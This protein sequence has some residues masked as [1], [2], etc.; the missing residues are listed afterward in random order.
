MFMYTKN[1]WGQV[2]KN[3]LLEETGTDSIQ[4]R[5][6]QLKVNEDPAL[7]LLRTAV[8][9][10]ERRRHRWRAAQRCA[11]QA[12]AKEE[13]YTHVISH[14]QEMGEAVFHA[15]VIQGHEERIDDDTQ[16][17]EQLHKRIEHY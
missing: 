11:R 13:E 3:V 1:L 4:W 16:S 14:L 17:D 2:M 12:M 6:R 7:Q 10:P 8:G 15:V 9:I 5:V